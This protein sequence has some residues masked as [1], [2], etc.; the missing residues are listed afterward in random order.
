MLET[1]SDSSE[2]PKPDWIGYVCQHG[3]KSSD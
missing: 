2:R 1:K 3:M